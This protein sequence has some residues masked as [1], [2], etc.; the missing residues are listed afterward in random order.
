MCLAILFSSLASGQDVLTQYWPEVDVYYRLNDTFRMRT[1]VAITRSEEFTNKTDATLNVDVDFSIKRM[2][3]ER[4]LRF[5]QEPDK[6]VSFRFGYAY[7]PTFSSEDPTR[8]HRLFLEVA[9]RAKGPVD[10]LMTDRN[11]IEARWIDGENS[12]RYRNRIKMEREFSVGS[13]R[14]NT[15]LTAEFY[16]D[17]RSSNW[18]RNEY[19]PGVEFPFIRSSILEI[20]YMRQDNKSSGSEDVNAIGTTIQ[21]YLGH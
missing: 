1:F 12:W 2:V 10:I 6:R 5:R 11:R 8:E 19:S 4:V 13:Y 14:F 9:P 15:Y 21:I 16:Y 7:V 3:T 18:T 17:S 20:Y